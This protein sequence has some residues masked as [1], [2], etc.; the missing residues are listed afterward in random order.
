M[1]GR[2]LLAGYPRIVPVSTR[3]IPCTR[4]TGVTRA[5][6]P[7]KSQTTGLFVEHLVEGNNIELIDD[8]HYSPFVIEAHIG[9]IFNIIKKLVSYRALSNKSLQESELGIGIFS[10]G[11]WKYLSYFWKR[12]YN[13]LRN[14]FCFHYTSKSS[15]SHRTK[16]TI[17]KQHCKRT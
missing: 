9:Q 5:S 14:S 1:A 10:I 3:V 15:Q 7:L 8:P 12:L 17:W 2:A 13:T 16:T 4:Y 6:Y 11:I